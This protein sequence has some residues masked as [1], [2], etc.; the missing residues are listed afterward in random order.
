M[1][2]QDWP[3]LEKA[4]KQERWNLWD[5][6]DTLAQWTYKYV[7]IWNKPVFSRLKPKYDGQISKIERQ[8]IS[9]DEIWILALAC[10]YY[11]PSFPK[12]NTDA[13][14]EFAE[15][16]YKIQS[17]LWITKPEIVID[18]FNEIVCSVKPEHNKLIPRL[19]TYHA[20]IH[21]LKIAYDALK[22]SIGKASL[23]SRVIFW[24]VCIEFMKLHIRLY[25]VEPLARSEEWKDL[26]WIYM[27]DKV[28]DDF[29]ENTPTNRESF[30]RKNLVQVNLYEELW[31][32]WVL[33]HIREIRN[34][35]DWLKRKKLWTPDEQ[36]PKDPIPKIKPTWYIRVVKGIQ[37]RIK[38]QWL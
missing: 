23:T 30:R 33:E 25:L 10:R 16:Q 15:Y 26:D 4:E 21:A 36:K 32:Q 29:S 37:W 12:D 2:I 5:Y 14:K 8:I 35:V 13:E 17:Y 3:T 31:L 1:H 38:W 24:L 6:L 18:F 11:K 7:H 20:Q 34:E 28:F 9:P 19:H 22:W 27:L